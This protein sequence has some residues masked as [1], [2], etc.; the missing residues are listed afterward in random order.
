MTDEVDRSAD[1]AEFLL[2]A[3]VKDIQGKVT[4]IP[5][6]EAGECDRCGETYPRLV[7]GNCSR[8]RDKFKLY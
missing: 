2:D 4:K 5:Q 3:Q 6:G 7:D 1:D 8:C